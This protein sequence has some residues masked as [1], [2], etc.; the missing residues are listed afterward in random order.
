MRDLTASEFKSIW[1]GTEL[2]GYP[3]EIYH[4]LASNGFRFNT[5]S[6]NQLIEMFRKTYN[7]G[8]KH[9]KQEVG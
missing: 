3:E 4:T 2:P 7:I 9:G 6:V 5:D 8:R 1:F